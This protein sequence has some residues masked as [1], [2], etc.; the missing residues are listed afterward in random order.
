MPPDGASKLS[1]AFSRFSSMRDGRN[2]LATA[3]VGGPAS[4]V[5]SAATA[6][7]APGGVKGEPRGTPCGGATRDSSGAVL[8]P[9]H[10]SARSTPNLKQTPLLTGCPSSV[11]ASHPVPMVVTS[12]QQQQQQLMLASVSAPA[13][14]HF[15]PGLDRIITPAFLNSALGDAAGGAAVAGLPR[16]GSGDGGHL[17]VTSPPAAQS[18]FV[19]VSPARHADSA[20]AV[21][22]VV[23]AEVNAAVAAEIL[24]NGARVQQIPPAR[25]SNAGSQRWGAERFPLFLQQATC[26]F[27]LRYLQTFVLSQY[28]EHLG[29]LSALNDSNPLVQQLFTLDLC[30]VS[31][32]C[33]RAVSK[34]TF[35]AI[36]PDSFCQIGIFPL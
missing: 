13:G 20:A 28:L 9:A 22:P 17:S 5:S 36:P 3:S 18:G 21:W 30:K 23:A 7:A 27:S 11:I 26:T 29:A 35:P 1:K 15:A 14:V 8:E 33:H 10:L 31:Q 16:L 19:A 2:P 4:I 24:R 25:L 34:Q 6:A 12:P 32:Q